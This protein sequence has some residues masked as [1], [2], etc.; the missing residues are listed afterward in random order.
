MGVAEYVVNRKTVGIP[1]PQGGTGP[2]G[3]Q[4]ERGERGEKGERGDAATV[5]VGSTVTL[6]PGGKASVSNSGDSHDAVLKFSIP[7]GD[8]LRLAAV[9]ASQ[10]GLPT[11]GVQVNDVAM[12]DGVLYVWDGSAWE[13][14]G[15]PQ[16]TSRDGIRVFKDWR[17]PTQVDETDVRTGDLWLVTQQYWTTA[18]GEPDDSPSALAD[19]YTYS[20]GEPD[21]SPSVLVPLDSIVIDLREWDGAAWQSLYWDVESDRNLGQSSGT[22]DGS[23]VASAAVLRSMP[24]WQVLAARVDGLEA[25][26]NALETQ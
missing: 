14:Q 15:R 23:A 3:P 2:R 24:E 20:E 1:G 13:S 19:F 26:L 10:S 18:L 9:A 4:G 7:K 6:P 12:A 21:N 17:D 11:S 22:G 8:G 5:R 16:V 25:R